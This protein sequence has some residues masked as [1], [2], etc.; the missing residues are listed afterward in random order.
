MPTSRCVRCKWNDAAPGEP[1]C[2][3]CAIGIARRL[4]P[5]D[6]RPELFLLRTA[7]GY[8]QP[9]L[10]C[11]TCYKT[12]SGSMKLKDVDPSTV[13]G[14][15]KDVQPTHACARCS[16]T[17]ATEI[18]HWAPT[19]LFADA[20]NWPK[21]PLCPACHRRWHVVTGTAGTSQPG[22]ELTADPTR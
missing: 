9:R 19:H 18:H 17:D 5:H 6:G 11:R 20:E 16:R 15:I 2:W 12:L 4:C 3:T 21:A 14:H 8:Q 7:N 1:I 22:R 13:D 10:R